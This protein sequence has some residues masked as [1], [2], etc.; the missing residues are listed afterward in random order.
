[1][2]LPRTTGEKVVRALRLQAILFQAG[3]PLEEFR[4]LL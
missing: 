3:I 2:K 1:M 4:D